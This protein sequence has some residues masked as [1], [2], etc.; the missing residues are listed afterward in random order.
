MKRQRTVR[1]PRRPSSAS[2]AGWRRSGLLVAVVAAAVLGS[3]GVAR[4]ET[5]LSIEAGW[6]DRYRPGQPLPVWVEVTAD[7][8]IQ[9]TLVVTGD[10]GTEVSVPVEVPGGS[11]KEYFLV[12]PT[13]STDDDITVRATL[14]AGDERAEDEAEVEYD[15]TV[16]LVGL[17][18]SVAPADLPA[19]LALS[20]DAGTAVFVEVT[21]DELARPAALASLGSLVAGPDDLGRLPAGSRL[22]ILTWV[23]AGGRL[24]VDAPQETAVAGLPEEWQ[25]DAS[26]RVAADLGEVRLTAGGAAAGRW[27]EIIEPTPNLSGPFV[28][29]VA[30]LGIGS[31]PVSDNIARDA[32]LR[33]TTPGWL[34]GF[35]IAYVVLAGPAAWLVLRTIKRPGLAWAVIPLVAVVF[36]AA[37]FVI[38]RDLRA[39]AQAAHGTVVAI[40]PGGTSATT[41]VGALSRNGVDGRIT[42]P[43]D[44]SVSTVDQ[45]WFGIDRNRLAVSTT[46][47]GAT[48]TIPLDAGEFGLLRS[49]GT[50][51]VDGGLVVEAATTGDNRISGTVRNTTSM[52]LDEVGVVAGSTG[53]N[54]GRLEPGESKPWDVDLDANPGFPMGD[55]VEVQVWRSAT[56]WDG[57]ADT[58]GAVSIALWSEANRRFGLNFLGSG[59]VVAAGW[60]S[61]LDVPARDDGDD[62]ALNGRSLVLGRGLI[63]AGA[64]GFHPAS[65]RLEVLRTG[66]AL[67]AALDDLGADNRDDLR[68]HLQRLR[69]PPGSPTSGF[70]LALGPD[71]AAAQVWMGEGWDTIDNSIEE[72]NPNVGPGAA[73]DRRVD[74]PGG[75]V[76]DGTVYLR[77]V[78]NTFFG[79]AVPPRL[80]LDLQGGQA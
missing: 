44:W 46:G 61:E 71:V 65:V 57:K 31:F 7:R 45:S 24:L 36:A 18:A 69:L 10:D 42:L 75:A 70:E 32:G 74:L 54:I 20:H 6:A 29:E 34:L 26:G 4:A 59:T 79:P 67:D 51:A 15:P 39:G 55:P 58:T 23:A 30:S 12:V 64:A 19:P 47:Q 11:V 28:D 48:A 60:T 16:D 21:D 35:L 13:A 33:L 37:S 49:E 22:G 68:A 72:S 27:D 53:T 56:G 38:G 76:I 66:D 80:S 17:T 9:G 62:E 2:V 40:G 43:A 1:G 63:D 3:P 5:R 41:F 77:T 78:S 8:L 14:V 52:V 73:A 25:P 50:M